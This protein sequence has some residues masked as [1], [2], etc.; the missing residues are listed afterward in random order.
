MEGASV[1]R[2]CSEYSLPLLE[3]RC[4]SNLVEDR[5]LSRWRLREACEKAAQA[6]VILI[7]NLKQTQA[8]QA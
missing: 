5:D 8:G 2:V 7:K 4:I 6:A 3:L 1:A